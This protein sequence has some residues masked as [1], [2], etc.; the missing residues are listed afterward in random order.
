MVLVKLNTNVKK[1]AV[2]WKNLL[3]YIAVCSLHKFY[4]TGDINYYRLAKTYYTYISEPRKAEFPKELAINGKKYNYLT[5]N[6]EFEQIRDLSF[7]KID[8]KLQIEDL[9]QVVTFALPSKEKPQI[10]HLNANNSSKNISQNEYLEEQ[11]RLNILDRK[12]KFYPKL[13]SV[14][15]GTIKVIEKDKD[16]FGY[17]L[18]NNY[19][20]FEK[21]YKTSKNKDELKPCKETAIYAVTIDTA[22]KCEFDLKRMREYISK[23]KNKKLGQRLYHTDSNSYQ[24]KIMKIAKYPNISSV[25]YSDLK[26][27][28]LNNN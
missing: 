5:F 13:R 21:F 26:K 25:S 12:L 9:E 8:I 20:I 10:G 18:N 2:V 24:E 7:P 1:P 27:L 22:V 17:V 19:I 28:T 11:K 6:T 3:L 16:Y 23:I 15:L 4:E 14:T